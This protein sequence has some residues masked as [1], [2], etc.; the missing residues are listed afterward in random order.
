M[1]VTSVQSISYR[2]ERRGGSSR[3]LSPGSCGVGLA[4]RVTV[5][6]Q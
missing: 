4:M 3:P 2:S 5:L 1:H 6:A